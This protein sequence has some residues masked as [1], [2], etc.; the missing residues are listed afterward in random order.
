[1]STLLASPTPTCL[2]PRVLVSGASCI[3]QIYSGS[4]Q[5]FALDFSKFV[6]VNPALRVIFPRSVHVFG[7]VIITLVVLPTDVLSTNVST[8]LVVEIEQ[9]VRLTPTPY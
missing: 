2:S 8:A 4:L 7:D 6:P 5:F 3:C 9:A 1:M